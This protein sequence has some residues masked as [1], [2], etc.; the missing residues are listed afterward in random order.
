MNEK[1][2]GKIATV[3]G[4]FY[5]MDRDKR[6]ERVVRAYDAIAKGEGVKANSAVAAIEESYQK[7]IFDEFEAPETGSKSSGKSDVVNKFELRFF[8]ILCDSVLTACHIYCII[9]RLQAISFSY[10]KERLFF[11]DFKNFI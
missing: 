6:W 1:G 2:V 9:N 11:M 10:P 4:R 5:A 7:E 8:R 3:S